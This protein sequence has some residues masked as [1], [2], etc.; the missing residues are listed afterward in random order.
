VES[1]PRNPFAPPSAEVRDSESAAANALNAKLYTQT[2]IRA[3]SFL[4]GPIAAVYLL[5]ENFR[6]L[7]RAPEAR[8]TVLWGVVV[9]AGILALLPFLPTRFPNYLIPLLYMFGAGYVADQW[10]L[11]KQAILDSGKYRIQSNWR[12]FGMSVLCL[13]AFTLALVLEMFVLV[14]LGLVHL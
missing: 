12:V 13:I 14:A 1:A 8:A 2:Q 5:R 4:G 6:V 11:R 7:D 3:G 10:Q 9:I